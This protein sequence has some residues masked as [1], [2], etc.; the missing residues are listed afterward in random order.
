VVRVPTTVLGQGDSG[1]GVKNGVNAFGK[2]NF[3]GTF[4]PPFAVIND[5][6]FLDTLPLR[7]QIAGMAEA[8]KV[9]LIKDASFF[10]FIVESAAPLSRGERAPVEAL[11]ERCAGLH[12]EH[13]RS[14]GDPFELGSKRPLDFGHWAAHKLES[15]TEHRLRHGECV[16]IGMALD[17][18][19]ASLVGLCSVDVRD[20][21]LT[22]LETLGFALWDEALT[23]LADGRPRVLEGLAEFR[24]HLGGE[25]TVTMLREVGSAVEVHAIDERA[26]IAALAQ[27]EQ[28]AARR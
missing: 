24:E 6:E 20:T 12:L 10:R 22:T 16:A 9:A 15:L 11:V 23:M 8:V 2:K 4:A 27:L 1:V 3:L 13:I 26:M 19:Y 28:R 17:T 25:L 7:D 14:G 5:I 18:V 21:V